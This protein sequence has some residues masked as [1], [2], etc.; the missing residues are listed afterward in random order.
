[1]L[2]H[3]LLFMAAFMLQQQLGSCN[4]KPSSLQS[5]RYLQSGP[6]E[7]KFSQLMPYIIPDS[8]LLSSVNTTLNRKS[9][10]M[11]SN[12]NCKGHITRVEDQSSEYKF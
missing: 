2:I 4:S 9:T 7:K 3:L 11:A 1:M 8:Q 12:I 5:L 10:K 6:L